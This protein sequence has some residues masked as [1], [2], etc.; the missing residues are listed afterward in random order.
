MINWTTINTVLLD[1]DGTLLDLHFDN[2]FWQTYIPLKYAEKH[3]ISL[4]QANTE[5]IPRFERVKGTLNWYCLD[6]WNNELKM[7]LVAMKEEVADKLNLRPSAEFF[8]KKLKAMGKQVF[9]ITNAHPGSLSL[10][11]HHLPIKDYFDRLI[12]AHEYGVPKE[13]PRFWSTLEADIHLRKD[14][15]LFIDDGVHILDAA[16]QYGVAHLLAIR[17]PDSHQNPWDTGCYEAVEDYRQLF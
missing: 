6:Y 4:K 13:S 8:L 12:S 2:Y 3:R 16:R 14:R 15:A 11:M 5:L 9:M 17:C 1:M 10:K 7:D